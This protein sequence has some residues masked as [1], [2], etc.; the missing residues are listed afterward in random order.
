MSYDN[1][2]TRLAN[3]QRLTDRYL[4]IQVKN[5][6]D[7]EKAKLG[8]IF[9]LVEIT[10]PWFPNSQIGQ[11]IIN[12]LSQEYYKQFDNDNVQNFENS[13][14]KVNQNLMRITQEGETNWVGNLNAVLVIISE[15]EIHLAK[16]GKAE[17]FLFREGKIK[18]I[19]EPQASDSEPNPIKTF[20]DITSG[21]LVENDKLLIT[22]PALLDYLSQKEL[23]SIIFNHNPYEGVE[24]IAQFLKKEKA[25]HINACLIEI[26]SKTDM[27][28]KELQIQD[29]V[30]LD[31]VSNL[32]VVLNSTKNYSAKI[33]PF[34]QNTSESI[35]NSFDK[36]KHFFHKEVN[37]RAKAGWQKTKE[38]SKK[39]YDHLSTKTAPQIKKAIS[40][41]SA[42]ISDGIKKTF[43]KKTATEPPAIPASQKTAL[44]QYSVNYYEQNGLG[45]KSSADNKLGTFWGST[46]GKIKT[47][48]NQLFSKEKKSIIYISLLVLLIVVLVVSVVELR[49][50]QN[51]KKQEEAQAQILEGAKNKY[52][53]ARLAILYNDPDKARTL[54]DETIRE[55]ME[56][57]NNYP[58]LSDSAKDIINKSNEEYD[59]LTKTTRFNEPKMI[60][61]FKQADKIFL[62]ND[63]FIAV[64]YK[65][66]ALSI[67]NKEGGQVGS[68][69]GIN[70]NEGLYI[71][72]GFDDKEKYLYFLTNKNQLFKTNDTAKEP[73]KITP[74]NGSWETGI[75][76][77]IFLNN[78]YLLDQS[79]AQIFK[80]TSSND[81]YQAG[82][83]YVN[84]E[85]V[86]LKNCV[87]MTIDG[88]VFVLKSDGTILKLNKGIMQDFSLKNLPSPSDKLT[89]PKKIWTTSEISSLFVLDE[90]RIVE[91]D[92]EGKFIRQF[93]FSPDLQNINDF[94]I[95]PTDKKIWVLNQNKLYSSEF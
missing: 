30:Y 87:S 76:I 51:T 58:K 74:K 54:L 12:T 45:E 15:N 47:G 39:G 82:T 91:F 44:E 65:N 53:E 29:V 92:K 40:P 26:V 17:V 59:K 24:N 52:N 41:I 72:W 66:N 68:Q 57:M 84:S 49:N 63:K 27:E 6:S 69:L 79:S 62:V 78:I 22:S 55:A 8:R 19:T 64:N 4:T 75:E 38:L 13:L 71:A 70:D 73:E 50:K 9:A 67:V 31:Q 25:R 89:K 80:H 18:K 16:T 28:N 42:K 93:A 77:S 35:R 85:S 20:I 10:N 86:D 88:N 81:T 21:E 95:N 56:I 61:E 60:A 32:N 2:Y 5:P 33:G 46:T 94:I 34:L 3:S 36:V 48:W 14:K 37:P 7:P 23:E 43:S 11:N 90:N 1:L 83:N